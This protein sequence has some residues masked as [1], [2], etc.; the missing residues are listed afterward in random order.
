MNLIQCRKL[1]FSLIALFCAIQLG[2]IQVN[3]IPYNINERVWISSDAGFK[4]GILSMAQVTEPSAGSV[5]TAG[6][7][8]RIYSVF[9]QLSTFL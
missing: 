1:N 9:I 6:R 2:S 8:A 3:A 5:H 7:Y 4:S